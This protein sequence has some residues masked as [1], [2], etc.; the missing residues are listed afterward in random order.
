MGGGNT[1]SPSTRTPDTADQMDARDDETDPITEFPAFADVDDPEDIPDVEDLDMT[2]EILKELRA[3]DD[4]DDENAGAAAGGETGLGDGP[5]AT[6][7]PGEE[8]ETVLEQFAV[9][10]ATDAD[11]PAEFAET[12]L[13]DDA[14]STRFHDDAPPGT[15]EGGDSAQSPAEP[16]RHRFGGWSDYDPENATGFTPITEAVTVAGRNAEYKDVADLSD[17]PAT[18]TD[19]A[20]ITYYADDAKPDIDTD[21]ER[22]TYAHR[23][24]VGYA[25]TDA[26]GARVP[27]HTFNTDGA[28]VAK[29]GIDG[30]PADLAPQTAAQQVDRAEFI[31]QMAVQLLAG[32]D[33]LHAGNVFIG[34]DGRVTCIDL[35][36]A[37]HGWHD[38]EQMLDGASQAIHDVADPI[39]EKRAD[40]TELDITEEE[41]V[42]RAQE[43]AVSLEVS[44][45]KQQVFETLERYD[46]VFDGYYDINPHFGP[47][48]A[49]VQNNIQL[50]INNARR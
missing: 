35:D 46:S 29:A 1:D 21:S 41:L 17:D 2:P 13:V 37:G 14:V 31:D 43:I 10:G 4:E 33:D 36:L 39:D 32:N 19:E 42:A 48:G 16:D 27:P 47:Y 25:A 7:P 12:V 9:D 5:G 18:G 38:R 45:Q 22:T 15:V 49:R 20:Y 8:E 3:E 34:D 26:I 28:W 11:T 50:L 24:M 6:G 30:R 40:G 23:E 44:G